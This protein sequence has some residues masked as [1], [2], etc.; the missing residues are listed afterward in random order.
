MECSTLSDET[1]LC[2][3]TKWIHIRDND[4]LQFQIH[5]CVCG[6][7]YDISCQV[8]DLNKV[9][10]QHNIPKF[11]QQKNKP[12]FKT[13]QRS[14]ISLHLNSDIFHSGQHFN[15]YAVNDTATFVS[16]LRQ[17]RC[18]LIFQNCGQLLFRR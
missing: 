14:F 6:F 11:V 7:Q 1:D 16:P 10:K 8:L 4:I 13:R 9:L 15:L 18:R 2:M 3:N 12:Y 17:H 5:L